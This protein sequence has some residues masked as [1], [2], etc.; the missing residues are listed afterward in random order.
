MFIARKRDGGR[1][2]A[3]NKNFIFLRRDNINDVCFKESEN[4]VAELTKGNLLLVVVTCN[5]I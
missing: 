2:W 5:E 1:A 3:E 4:A